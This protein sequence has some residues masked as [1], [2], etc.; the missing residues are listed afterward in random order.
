MVCL[1]NLAL[2]Y[3]VH[4]IAPL[5]KCLLLLAGIIVEQFIKGKR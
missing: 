4:D 2:H 3:A 5:T 1:K